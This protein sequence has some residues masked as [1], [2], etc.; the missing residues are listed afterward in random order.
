MARVTPQ[1]IEPTTLQGYIDALETAFR[2]ALGQD[3]SLS[4]ENVSVSV[5]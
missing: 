3:L 1:G 2:S 4:S 5:Q